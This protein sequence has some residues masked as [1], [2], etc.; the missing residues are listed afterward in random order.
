[1]GVKRP[2]IWLPG[3]VRIP[4]GL[5]LL[6]AVGWSFGALAWIL[7]AFDG[8][9]VEWVRLAS[10]SAGLLLAGYFWALYAHVNR[11]RR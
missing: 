5:S 11:L 9:A 2:T 8:G 7:M 4:P 1:M 3:G 10:A 6:L